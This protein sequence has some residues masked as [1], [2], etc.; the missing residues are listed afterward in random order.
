LDVVDAARILHSI[1]VNRIA[2]IVISGVRADSELV[3][4]ELIPV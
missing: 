2:E 3:Y 1:G 4:Q